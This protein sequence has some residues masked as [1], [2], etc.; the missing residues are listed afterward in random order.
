MLWSVVCGLCRFNW[1][2][3]KQHC[4]STMLLETRCCSSVVVFCSGLLY[5]PRYPQINFNLFP[6]SLARAFVLRHKDTVFEPCFGIRG[7]YADSDLLLYSNE[8]TEYVLHVLQVRY[9]I[10]YVIFGRRAPTRKK[11]ALSLAMYV[12]AST[13]STD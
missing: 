13:G 11:E 7:T 5:Y 4:G 2:W 3:P 8:G 9:R 1:N 10:Q 12:L 6:P